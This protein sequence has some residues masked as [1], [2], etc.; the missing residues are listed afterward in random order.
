MGRDRKYEEPGIEIYLGD[1]REL[2]DMIP[3]NSVDMVFTDPPYMRRYLPL[4]SW[5]GEAAA[6]ILGE[7]GF[8]FAYSGAYH[9]YEVMMRLGKYLNYFWDF[10]M[11]HSGR[12][13]ICWKRKIISGYKS[14]LCYCKGK[15]ALPRCVALGLLRSLG[16]DKRFH[17]W[18][19]SEE[20]IRYL[21]DTF[22]RPGDLVVDPFLGGGTTAVVCKYLGRR[23][24]G[25]EIDQDAFDISVERVR[26]QGIPQDGEQ[27]ELIGEAEFCPGLPQ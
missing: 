23:F 19:Q 18:G 6:R 3:D 24:I 12:S 22:S 9:K 1:A 2:V 16:S 5:I 14:I 10:V 20:T 7:D 13:S 15:N 26:C 4:Y 27:L 25:F 8:L 17:I 21:L 11:V